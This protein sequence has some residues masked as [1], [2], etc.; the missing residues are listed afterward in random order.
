MVTTVA[1][2]QLLKQQYLEVRRTTEGLCAR[3]TPEDQMVQS[4]ME[5]SPTKWHQAHTT[6][7]FE[8]FLLTPRLPGYQAFDP[9]FRYLFNSYYKQLAGEGQ[10]HPNRML[11]GMFSRPGLAEIVAYRAHVDEAMARLLEDLDE[12]AQALVELGI[13][14]EQQHQELIVTDIKHAFWINPLRPAYTDPRAGAPAPHGAAPAPRAWIACAG[15]LREIG[16]SGDGFAFDNEGPRHAV[17]LQP[18][19]IASRLVT[20]GEYR[21]FIDEGGYGR[22][23]L[24]LSDGWDRAC[25]EGWFA[26]LYWE[27]A[28][29][30]WREFTCGGM[31][32]L[33]DDEP[34]CHV[35]YYEADAFARWAGARLATEQE[36]EIASQVSGVRSQVSGANL[37]EGGR[38]HPR[39]AAD[40]D[41]SAA[42]S[43][44]S[45]EGILPAQLFG[46]CWEWTASAYLPYP[47]YRAAAGALGEYNGKFMSGQMVLRGGSC[48]T[49][50]SHI[51][52]TYRNFFPPQARWQ[53][54]G[55]RLANDGA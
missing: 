55:I 4:A 50:A 28:D 51:R 7:F 38:F 3:L 29:G 30:G 18:F 24:W 47:G 36:W 12:E 39:A 37:L 41:R 5:C 22:S 40:N 45:G 48:A 2:P 17:Y 23:E 14:H 54:M 32:D 33:L 49:P 10:A 16:H 9:A 6:W 35:S 34:V 13:N 53:F 20:N 1:A 52:A 15:G 8:T 11:R 44:G 26:P 31:R 19:R 25:A 21:Q 42:V 27:R 46:D 43:R